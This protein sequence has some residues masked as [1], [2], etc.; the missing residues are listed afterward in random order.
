MSRRLA[1]PEGAVSARSGAATV[2]LPG[3]RPDRFAAL[4]AEVAA[5]PDSAYNVD[6]FLWVLA[7]PGPRPCC[8]CGTWF[9]PGESYDGGPAR[10]LPRRYCSPRCA[11]RATEVRRRCRQH[12]SGVGEWGQAA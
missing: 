6:R 2:A 10:G 1:G 8:S 3:E 5:D 7:E 11:T 9:W 4:V 12:G